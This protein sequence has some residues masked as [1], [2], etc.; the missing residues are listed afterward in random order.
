MGGGRLLR[1]TR[2]RLAWSAVVGAVVASAL[3]GASTSAET[4]RKAPPAFVMEI[5]ADAHGLAVKG[6]PDEKAAQQLAENIARWGFAGAEWSEVTQGFQVVVQTDENRALLLA[7]LIQAY[8]NRCA[9]EDTPGNQAKR[10]FGVRL[11]VDDKLTTLRPLMQR[12]EKAGYHPRIVEYGKLHA[13]VV[14][15]FESLKHA[16][17]LVA[18]MLKHDF[19]GWVVRL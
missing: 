16:C 18:D 1:R 17:W 7:R 13:L 2:R 11:L 3:W 9:M 4:E 8:G 14:G 15:E 5:H 6:L 12:L 19:R 10:R